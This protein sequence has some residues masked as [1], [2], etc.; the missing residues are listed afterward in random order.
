M[1]RLWLK[2]VA[3]SEDLE[4]ASEGQRPDQYDTNQLQSLCSS[5]TAVMNRLKKSGEWQFG[6]A[7]VPIGI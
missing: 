6:E 5:R 4:E 2:T 7:F 3:D 1:A